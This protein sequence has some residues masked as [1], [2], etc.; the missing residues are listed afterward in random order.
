MSLKLLRTH[1]WVGKEGITAGKEFGEDS[2]YDQIK[3]YKFHLCAYMSRSN[4]NKYRQKWDEFL[5][6]VR[7]SM[8]WKRKGK[9]Q[10]S[11]FRKLTMEFADLPKIIKS[12]KQKLIQVTLL[13]CQDT[14]GKC[15]KF[16]CLYNCWNESWKTGKTHQL[17]ESVTGPVWFEGHKSMI[18]ERQGSYLYI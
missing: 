15:L 17:R 16:S 11:C 9:S 3:L 6:C 12:L 5:L 10:N 14:G 4:E 8:E 1:S 13:Q 7:K 2:E 18:W